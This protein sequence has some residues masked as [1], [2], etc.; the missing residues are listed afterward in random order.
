MHS[1]EAGDA[2]T[3]KGQDRSIIRAIRGSKTLNLKNKKARA[4]LSK[5]PGHKPGNDLL[6]RD[7]SSYYHWLLGA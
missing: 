6:S 4:L 7:L 5:R 3:R 1:F 2:A